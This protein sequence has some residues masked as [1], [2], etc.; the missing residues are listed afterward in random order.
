[1]IKKLEIS[2]LHGDASDRLRKYV[3][4]KVNKLERHIPR[5]ARRSVH[6]EVHLKEDDVAKGAHT[7]VAEWIVHVPHATLTAKEATINIYA[8]V[9]I[10]EAKLKN[11]IKKYKETHSP[12]ASRRLYNRFK[13]ELYA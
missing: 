3:V 11:Q 8:A 7:S 6:V 13:P 10:V 4:K 2:G 1:M 12:S 9:D 5:H